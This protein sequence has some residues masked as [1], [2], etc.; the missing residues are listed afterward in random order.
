MVSSPVPSNVNNP[1]LYLSIKNKILAQDKAAGRKWGAYSSGRLVQDY[2]KAG[3]TYS[4]AKPSPRGYVSIRS[5]KGKGGL[6]QWFN[7]EWVDE[8]GNECGS[9]KNKNTK[10][11]RPRKRVNKDTP[12]TW[13]ELSSDEKKKAVAEKK[14]VGMGKRA[15]SLKRS[16]RGVLETA[17]SDFKKTKPLYKPY[18]STRSGK[19]GMVYV[20][21]SSK[22]CGKGLIH[23]GDSSMS[24]YTNHKS[25]ERR[26]NYRTRSA[27]I[28]DAEG[29][30]TKDDKNSA[31]YWSR[32]INW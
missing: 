24:D 7:E 17:P 6:R 1:A 29:N 14:A 16:D 32:K 3:G 5:P 31:N 27:G 20:K 11:C 4:G 30:L 9:T 2:K 22:K 10:K 28:R 12:V 23:F 8:Y 15:P 18:R 21:D 19:K 13:K 25:P 26:R